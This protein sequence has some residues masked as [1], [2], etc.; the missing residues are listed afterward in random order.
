MPLSLDDI[1]QS[2]WGS[3]EGARGTASLDA[4]TIAGSTLI[5]CAA[6]GPE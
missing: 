5:I 1:I 2:K 4:A 6:S 3:F